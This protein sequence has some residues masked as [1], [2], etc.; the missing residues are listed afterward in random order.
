[1]IPRIRLISKTSTLSAN[2]IALLI[3]INYV[4]NYDRA[5]VVAYLYSFFEKSLIARV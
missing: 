4:I 2:K 3:I 5:L 1:M